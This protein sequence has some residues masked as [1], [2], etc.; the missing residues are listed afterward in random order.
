METENSSILYDCQ[1]RFEGNA[2]L[3]AKRMPVESYSALT[4]LS[5]DKLFDGIVV[6]I[7]IDETMNGGPTRYIYKNNQWSLLDTTSEI[8]E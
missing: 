1:I 8:I 3:D 2:Y 4:K 5:A 7:K 6:G